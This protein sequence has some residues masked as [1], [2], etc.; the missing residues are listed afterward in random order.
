MGVQAAQIG[1]RAGYLDHRTV[2][3]HDRYSVFIIVNRDHVVPRCE[4]LLVYEAVLEDLDLILP[5]NEETYQ[6][7]DVENE[8]CSGEYQ[9]SDLLTCDEDDQHHEEEYE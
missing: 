4:R 1:D 7:K 3:F 6:G 2:G 8:K 5:L 9:I